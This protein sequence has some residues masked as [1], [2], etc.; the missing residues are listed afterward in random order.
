MSLL[1]IVCYVIVPIMCMV[2]FPALAFLIA[3]LFKISSK[4]TGLEHDYHHLNSNVKQGFEGFSTQLQAME[5]DIK[6]LL[7]FSSAHKAREDAK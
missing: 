7:E 6:T 2:L 1:E 3:F 4:V 5:K